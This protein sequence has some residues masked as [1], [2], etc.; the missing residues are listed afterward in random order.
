PADVVKHAAG[1]RHARHAHEDA[2]QPETG[3]RA[4][5]ADVVDVQLAEHDVVAQIDHRAV[6]RFRAAAHAVNLEPAERD[7]AGALERE[8]DRAGVVPAIEFRATDMARLKRHPCRRRAAAA[9][10]DYGTAAGI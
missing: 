1:D 8:A 9:Q 2:G 5:V 10:T 4:D 3:A 6:G 7:V